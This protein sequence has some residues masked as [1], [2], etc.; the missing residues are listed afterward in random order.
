[1]VRPRVFEKGRCA[2]FVGK[3]PRTLVWADALHGAEPLLRFGCGFAAE[4]P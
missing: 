4:R 2:A 3:T 1:M